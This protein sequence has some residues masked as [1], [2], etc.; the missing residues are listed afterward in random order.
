MGYPVFNAYSSTLKQCFATNNAGDTTWTGI[1]TASPTNANVSLT[2]PSTAGSYNYTLTC[3]GMES[4]FATLVVTPAP[5]T[6]SATLNP[7]SIA[8]GNQTANI[9]S[10]AATVTLSNPG[11]ATLNIAGIS[12]TGT[13][14]TCVGGIVQSR[15]FSRVTSNDTGLSVG[16][17]RNQK[18]PG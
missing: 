3:G 9:T 14:S 4:G 12:L 2:A 1:Y 18:R 16:V 15:P 10:A 11:T 8:F 7:T 17:S 6:P 13:G 5:S